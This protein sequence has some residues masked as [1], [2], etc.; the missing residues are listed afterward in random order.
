[1]AFDRPIEADRVDDLGLLSSFVRSPLLGPIIWVLEKR[2]SREGRENIAKSGSTPKKDDN[3][4]ISSSVGQKSSQDLYHGEDHHSSSVVNILSTTTDEDLL[5]RDCITPADEITASQSWRK[6]SW[7]DES[8]QDLVHYFDPQVSYS[9]TKF[10]Q[11]AFL[12]SL[13]FA[14]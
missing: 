9:S 13:Y 8:G 10:F 7:S 6:T 1:M 3:I 5:I 4:N 11:S 14:L 2:L 12:C